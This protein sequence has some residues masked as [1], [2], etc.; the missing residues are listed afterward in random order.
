MKKE[1]RV[2]KACATPRPLEIFEHEDQA[3]R[4]ATLEGESGIFERALKGN[5]DIV[6]TEDVWTKRVKED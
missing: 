1:L 2:L 5:D 3:A 6:R 4:G